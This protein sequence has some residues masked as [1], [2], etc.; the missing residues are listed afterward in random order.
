VTGRGAT[1]AAAAALLLPVLPAAADLSAAI[2]PCILDL[3]EDAYEYTAVADDCPEAVALIEQ[4]RLSGSIGED[5]QFNLTYWQAE[6]LQRLEEYYAAPYETRAVNP[7]VL[8]EIVDRLEV[9]ESVA[10]DKSLWERFQDWLRD[11]LRDDDQQ[12]PGWLEDW[13]SD[14]RVPQSALETIFWIIAAS[15]IIGALLVIGVEIRAARTGVR[16]SKSS[17]TI[18]ARGVAQ[19]SYSVLTLDDLEAAVAAE[20][21][22]VLLRLL[23]QRLERLGIV[24]RRPATTHREV[25]SQAALDGTESRTLARVSASAEG[26][27]YGDREIDAA[28]LEDLVSSG[29]ATLR[30]LKAR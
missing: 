25:V 20:K 13:L 8:D 24:P 10:E 27:R 23:L 2:E 9:P 21:P 29:V 18:V 22:A 1:L 3:D 15:I 26:V 30:G 4:Y 7:D 14:F 17:R 28:E 19:S 11:V 5:W 6:Q 12:A 16:S